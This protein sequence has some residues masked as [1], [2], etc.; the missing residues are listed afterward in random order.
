MVDSVSRMDLVFCV[1]LT[2][3]M[4]SFIAAA[5][6]SIAGILDA[7]RAALGDG[8][9]VGIV[10]YRDHCDG[11][12]LLDITPPD[13]DVEKVRKKIDGFSVSGGG[14]GPEAV[15]AGLDA[16]VKLAW[17]DGC[18]RVVILV[19]DAPP[20]AL[21]A[22]GDHHP[23]HD[24]SGHDLDGMA[25]LLEAEGIFVH[26]LA[27]IPS[28]KILE[29]AFRRL[30]ISTGGAYHDAASGDAAMRIVQSITKQFLGDLDFDRRLLGLLPTVKAPVP[31][32]EDEVV[33][34]RAELL[35]KRMSVEI[36][37]IHSG[38]MRLRQR[39]LLTGLD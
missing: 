24:P 26:A 30:S 5:R 17:A 2:G 16:C 6:A 25:N 18:Y 33:P 21:G 35:A 12:M 11:A 8:L 28:D 39:R 4:G 27:L 32:T 19:G 38:M 36:N 15:Y 3:S 37:A 14:D 29:K 20:H 7:L 1:D 23:R 34:S 22:P 9:R 31:A 10:G 13:G